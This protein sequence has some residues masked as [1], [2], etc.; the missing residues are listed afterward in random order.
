MKV[1]RTIIV[2][3]LSALVYFGL[4]FFD[5]RTPGTVGLLA[6]IVAWPLHRIIILLAV[7]G[8]LRSWRTSGVQTLLALSACLAASA[9]G[10]KLGYD[11]RDRRFF[12]W[13]L[14]V[15]RRVVDRIRGTVDLPDFDRRR[16]EIELMG[17]ESDAA[18]YAF[19]WLDESG[20]LVVQFAW[21]GMGPPPKHCLYTYLA[22]GERSE[23][24]VWGWNVRRLDEF[25]YESSD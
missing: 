5:A 23:S 9:A 18:R 4:S 1:T 25:W 6:W 12:E 7:V 2:A 22:A 21:A 19:A 13:R 24:E 16:H 20:Q 14:P 17:A 15:Y 11:A 10:T 3:W 8:L